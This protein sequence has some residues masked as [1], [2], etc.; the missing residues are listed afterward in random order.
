MLY[1]MIYHKKIDYFTRR[2]AIMSH[3]PHSP[4]NE[5]PSVEDW[6]GQLLPIAESQPGDAEAERRD[7]QAT[8]SGKATPIQ[9]RRVLW[10]IL[11]WC[12][13][14]APIATA[15][16]PHMTYFHDGA[17]NIGLHLLARVSPLAESAQPSKNPNESDK[18]NRSDQEKQK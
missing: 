2:S 1:K 14:F 11:E 5:P 4:Y 15:G 10:R 8:F 17:R 3:T 7:F 18:A 13:I 16:D 9:A 6:L 12:R